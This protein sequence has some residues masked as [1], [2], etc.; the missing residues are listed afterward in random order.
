MNRP[1]KVGVLYIMKHEEVLGQGVN[2]PSLVTFDFPARKSILA[3]VK[4]GIAYC[5]CSVIDYLVLSFVKLFYMDLRH[6]TFR[7]YH[8]ELVSDCF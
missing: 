7:H 2:C 5:E 8:L 3:W 6:K 4:L 1:V